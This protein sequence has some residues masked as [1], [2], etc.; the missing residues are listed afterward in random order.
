MTARH[1]VQFFRQMAL[2]LSAGFLI[3]EA[4]A[5]LRDRY[6]DAPSRRL[7]REVHARVSEARTSFSR[8]LA[9]FPRSFSPGTVAVIEAGEEAG[10]ARLAERLADLADRIAYAR[11]NR[12]QVRQACA[13][14]AFVL[15]MAGGLYVLLLGVVFPRLAAL[16]ATLGG[17]LP[18]L[19][20]AVISVSA[21]VRSG[22]PFVAG[23]VAALAAAIAVLRRFPCTALALDRLLLRLPFAGPAY[24]DLTAALICKIYRQLYQ[25]NKPAPEIV[26]LCAHLTGNAAIRH[27]LREIRRAIMS[28]TATLA[29]A[30]S[31]SGLLPP[32][33]CL[34]LEVGEQSG[35]LAPAMDRTAAYLD[36][37][38]RERIRAA[39]AVINP[40]LTLGIVGGVGLM[41]ISFFQAVY[42]VVYAPH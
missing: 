15:L 1:Q 32:L 26:D 8:A 29:G 5:R 3:T 35:Q 39:I 19:T 21:I 27:G 40:A 33:A 38:A 41:I 13:Y 36:D 42:Q 28:G 6:P 22:W 17:R 30:F 10:A 37:L 12:R 24:R 7:L 31:R 11:A 4:L 16:L 20:Q 34:A 25:A 2:L 18:P 9:L 23:G 14:P